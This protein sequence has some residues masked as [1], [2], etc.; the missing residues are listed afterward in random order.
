VKNDKNQQLAKLIGRRLREACESNAASE[1][2]ATIAAGLSKV[3]QA[4]D[5]PVAPDANT[6]GRQ[7]DEQTAVNDAACEASA[8]GAPDA[9]S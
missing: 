2:P 3:R 1:F 7:P 4:E 9:N 5:Q 6:Q 8:G